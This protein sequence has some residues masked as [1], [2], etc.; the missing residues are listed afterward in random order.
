MLRIALVAC[1]SLC[2]PSAGVAQQ[3]GVACEPTGVQM[4]SRIGLIL[5][6]GSARSLAH[7][8]VLKWFEEHRISIYF[9]AGSSIGA[10]VGG[11]YATG[12]SAAEV[13]ALIETIDWDAMFRGEVAYPLK[14]F[15]RKEERREFPVGLELGVRDGSDRSGYT[16]QVWMHTV[17]HGSATSTHWPCLGEASRRAGAVRLLGGSDGSDAVGGSASHASSPCAHGGEQPARRGPSVA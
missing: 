17:V 10:L 6:G 1:L 8:G 16:T 9:I 15:R 11:G 12:R 4:R 14:A 7:V 13:R 5:G 3:V 2:I